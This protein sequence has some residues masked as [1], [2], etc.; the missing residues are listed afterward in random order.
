[1]TDNIT[2]KGP[3]RDPM[4]RPLA[5]D[6]LPARPLRPA[7]LNTVNHTL[8]VQPSSVYHVEMRTSAVDRSTGFL[9]ATVP[10]Y[11]GLG[12]GF[13][14]IG[15]LFWN[16]PVFSFAALVVFWSGFIG[17]WFLSYVFTLIVSAEGIAMFEAI[18][19][20]YVIVRE[21][22]ERWRYYGRKP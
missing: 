13:V 8:D 21:Q 19:K 10:L 18:M 3:P 4:V 9:I 20:W 15:A 2:H 14:L 5:G 17:A 6:I 11:G 12:A 22:T 1:M 16:L 7:D